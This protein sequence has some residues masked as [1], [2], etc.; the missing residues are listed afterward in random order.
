MSTKIL[1][2]RNR[3]IISLVMVYLILAA[4]AIFA[5]FPFVWMA[6]SSIKPF[7]EVLLFPPTIIPR[8]PTL[9][10]YQRVLLF[11]PFMTFFLNSIIVSGATT[12]LSTLIAAMA[13]YSLARFRYRGRAFLSRGILLAY[14]FP[15]IL[16]VVPLFTGIANLGL[17]NTRQGLI[18]AYVTFTFPFSTWL[19]AAYFQTVPAEIE[20]AAKVDGAS[21]FQVFRLIALPIA[22]PGLVT[23]AI[24]AFI[25]SWNEFLYSLVILGG[26]KS[27]T[28]SVGL[29]SF[30][31]GE[32][33]QWGEVMAATTMIMIPTM[34]FFLLIQN[35]I[36][37][38]LTGGA[39]KG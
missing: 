12:I 10:F 24:F 36:V 25:N 20:E 7:D 6:L 27:K 34:L 19:L 35:R 38:G 13:G 5:A 3:R 32:F 28:L 22:A 15:Q 16:L 17:A 39:L 8:N 9:H 30:I 33:M 1:G 23:A 37:K 2:I 31:G 11:T 4:L 29:Y 26:G 14:I 21:N 18:L